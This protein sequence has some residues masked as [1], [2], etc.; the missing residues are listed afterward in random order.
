M[1]KYFKG[2]REAWIDQLKEGDYAYKYN[3]LKYK[4]GSLVP[5]YR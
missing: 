5:K 2:H 3:V 4:K 1:D